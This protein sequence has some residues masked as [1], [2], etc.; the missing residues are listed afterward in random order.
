MLMLLAGW[1]G[2]SNTVDIFNAK[3]FRWSTDVLSKARYYLAAT[4]LPDQG[5]AI[6]AGGSTGM[7]V[8]RDL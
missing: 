6:F 4:S 2:F 8:S 7:H 3:T 1:S 5:L